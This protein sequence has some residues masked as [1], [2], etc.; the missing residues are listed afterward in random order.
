MRLNSVDSA[1]LLMNTKQKRKPFVV[2]HSL[3]EL[4]HGK[5]AA[6]VQQL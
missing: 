1:V 3:M 4:L 6:L 2:L 5:K